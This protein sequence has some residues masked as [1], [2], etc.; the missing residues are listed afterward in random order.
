[1]RT[2]KQHSLGSFASSIESGQLFRLETK[3][4]VLSR[5]WKRGFQFQ[6]GV[7]PSFWV[8]LRHSN[9]GWLSLCLIYARCACAQCKSSLNVCQR[10]HNTHTQGHWF[11]SSSCLNKVFHGHGAALTFHSGQVSD[12]DTLGGMFE[13]NQTSPSYRSPSRDCQTFA[14]ASLRSCA[15]SANVFVFL[16]FNCLYFLLLLELLTYPP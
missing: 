8:F 11:L 6:A 16:I 10:I 14:L 4:Q 3:V 12:D 9:L 1:M 13:Q 2:P 7:T 5:G 15:S